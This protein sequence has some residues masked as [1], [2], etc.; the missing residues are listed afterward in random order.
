M[1]INDFQ[2]PGVELKQ[3]FVEATATGVSQLGVAVVG[4]Q[5]K[6]NTTSLIYNGTRADVKL[7]SIPYCSATAAN[8]DLVVKVDGLFDTFDATTTSPL[9]I[10][11]AS[12][13]VV[14]TE[15]EVVFSAAISGATTAF[16]SA[17]PEVG[18]AVDITAGT[19]TVSGVITAITGSTMNA[20]LIGSEL[21]GET[22]SGVSFYKELTNVQL[23]GT[24]I[25][26]V[27]AVDYLVIPANVKAIADGN[28][29]VGSSLV[30]AVTPY[31]FYVEYAPK[32]LATAGISSLSDIRGTFGDLN[33]DLAISLA[34][35]LLAAGGNIVHYIDVVPGSSRTM[36]D[37]D[38]YTTA[39]DY[40]DRDATIYSLVPATYDENI[41]KAFIAAA[42]RISDDV[43]SK[44]YRTVWYGLTPAT[45]SI[46]DTIIA[47]R[48]R[49]GSSFRA[50]A[51][52]A[53]GPMYNGK[54]VP[55][56]AVA[57]AA[58]GMRCYEPAYRPI[59]NLGYTFFSL[60][61]TNG[62]TASDL[63]AIGSNGIWIVA[64][65]YDGT[66]VNMRQLTTAASNNL[67]KD[68]ES[69][70][71]NA[72][73]IALTLC[74]VGE[75]LVGCSNIS[76]ALLTALYDTIKGI[77]DRYLINLTGNVYIGPQ[78]LNWTFDKLEQDPVQLD[79]VYA[80]ITCEPPKPFNR[81]VMTLRIV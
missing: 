36:P 14:G 74:H 15:A 6:R 8:T 13:A 68:E 40:L 78:L 28:Q 32:K 24:S 76:P 77:M 75:N 21:D 5:K 39:L 43:E 2:F 3:E 54:V 56:F 80:T 29:A 47:Q 81:F 20:T 58:A 1:A 31:S 60:A 26:T 59:S 49:I 10:T 7:S 70:V 12:S 30:A 35:A 55:T 52:W 64:N 4:Y 61:E 25:T 62:V 69:I 73:S 18:D 79:K 17:I 34:F 9:A 41:I 51:I 45:S 48:Q 66:P 11:T 37:V 72:D 71:A 63:N 67:N 16:G 65:N 50:Q 46:K 57:A 23:A 44:V 27:D 42:E 22:L 19:V 38:D 53:D 33:S